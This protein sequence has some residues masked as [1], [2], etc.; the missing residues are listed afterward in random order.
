MRVSRQSPKSKSGQTSVDADLPTPLYH[1]IYLILR[2]QIAAGAF[3]GAARMP[4]EAQISA[5]FSVSRITAKRAL[6]ELA[7][8]GLVVRRRGRGT[9]LVGQVAGAPVEA[10]ISGLIENLLAVG[11]ETKVDILEFGYGAAPE[12]VA[13][14]LRLAVGSEVQRAVRV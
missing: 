7:A 9:Q 6:D 8:E 1:Q 2:E 10:N 5:D 14:S 4:T 13:K 3:E 11:L 12:M